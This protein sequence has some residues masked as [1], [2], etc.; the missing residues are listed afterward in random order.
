M[1]APF[2]HT[3]AKL[4]VALY[5]TDVLHQLFCAMDKSQWIGLKYFIYGQ[6]A[7]FDVCLIN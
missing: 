3:C 7:G 5:N 2:A 1:V 4:D 6:L